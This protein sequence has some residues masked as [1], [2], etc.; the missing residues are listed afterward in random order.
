MINKQKDLL[1]NEYRNIVN[2]NK[3][4]EQNLDTLGFDSL[5]FQIKLID[6]ERKFYNSRYKTTDFEN[7]FYTSVMRNFHITVRR[8]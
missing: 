3:N 6:E 4:E 1:N 2:E 5:Y 8:N 7:V